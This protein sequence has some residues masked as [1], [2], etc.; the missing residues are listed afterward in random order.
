[1]IGEIDRLA[2]YRKAL[3]KWKEQ[4]RRF[5]LNS[6]LQI[7]NRKPLEKQPESLQFELSPDDPWAIKIRDA[8]LGKPIKIPKRKL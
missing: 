7:I 4:K 5:D 6:K 1:M 2:A 3:E 8:V